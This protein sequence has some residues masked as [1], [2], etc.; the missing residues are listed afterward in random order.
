MNGTPATPFA[1]A[2]AAMHP[3]ANGG[4]L[5]PSSSSQTDAV[6]DLTKEPDTPYAAFTL[7]AKLVAKSTGVQVQR[8]FLIRSLT[9]IGVVTDTLNRYIQDVGDAEYDKVQLF[10]ER[11]PPQQ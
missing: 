8:A 4:S 9:D 2:A 11:V 3:P 1:V 6:I 7:V 5:V 10:I